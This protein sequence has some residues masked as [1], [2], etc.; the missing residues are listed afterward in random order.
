MLANLLIV[1][2]VLLV[3]V[4][5]EDDKLVRVPMKMHDHDE[6]ADALIER[7]NQEVETDYGYNEDEY[8]RA[9]IKNWFNT[10]YFAEIGLF[11]YP[12]FLLSL[13]TLFLVFFLGSLAN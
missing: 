4:L 11:V 9:T 10:Q 12:E 8:G 3:S 7:R 2:A 6:F 13:L 1:L 5:G